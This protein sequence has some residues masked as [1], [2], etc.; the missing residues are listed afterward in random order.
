MDIFYFSGKIEQWRL[1][2]TQAHPASGDDMDAPGDDLSQGQYFV[3]TNK[4]PQIN[5]LLATLFN[6]IICRT[7]KMSLLIP[8]AA[9]GRDSGFSRHRCHICREGSQGQGRREQEMACWLQDLN[10]PQI[11]HIH[12]CLQGPNCGAAR[13][14]P[15]RVFTEVG[16]ERFA[17][18]KILSAERWRRSWSAQ[19]WYAKH[20]P[21]NRR[22]LP[23]DYDYWRFHWR[24][25]ASIQDLR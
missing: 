23:K 2:G 22:F 20:Q 11:S 12:S 1:L 8:C 9:E 5:L 4:S 19:C 17:P 16:A 25:S 7:T 24:A 13:I 21:S 6:L 10:L 18:V 15:C 3:K 14:D